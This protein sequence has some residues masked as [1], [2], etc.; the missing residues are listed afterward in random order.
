MKLLFV[1]IIT[2]NLIKAII[3]LD[4]HHLAIISSIMYDIDHNITYLSKF[5]KDTTNFSLINEYKAFPDQS[6]LVTNIEYCI[7]V[8]RGSEIDFFDSLYDFTDSV[9]DWI[10][11]IDFIL[12]VQLE[13]STCKVSMGFYTIGAKPLLRKINKDLLQ[14]INSGKRLVIG[15]H[16]RAGS[17]S[18]ILGIMLK[19][20]NPTVITFGEPMNL[21]NDCKDINNIK[22]IRI[23]HKCDIISNIN[24]KKIGMRHYGIPI[25]FGNDDCTSSIIYHHI[26]NYITYLKFNKII[27]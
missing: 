9:G 12:P 17:I 26:D 24:L 19:K 15:G 16:S 27:I 21:F 10:S 13:K 4:I 8:T 18:G 5:I 14:C 11:D 2:I 7:I 6:I 3:A 22:K 25:I 1:F 20:Y 23:A